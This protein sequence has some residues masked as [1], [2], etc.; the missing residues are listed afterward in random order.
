MYLYFYRYIMVQIPFQLY[1]N[2]TLEGDALLTIGICDDR[3]LCR[4]L[5]EAYIHLYE[6]KRGLLFNIS[7]FGSGEELLEEVNK[8]GIIFNLLFLDNSMKKLT[9]LETAKQIRQSE[10]LSTC[11]IVFVTSTDDYDQFTQV[12]PLQV[13]CK[14][15]SQE[16]IDEILNKVLASFIF[17]RSLSM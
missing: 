2:L 7:Q 9:G 10:S 11:N 13:V 12:Q 8:H 17:N 14:P 5:L 16:S 1:I 6:E 15:G 4:H 3:P